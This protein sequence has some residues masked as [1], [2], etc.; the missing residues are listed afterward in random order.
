MSFDYTTHV[1]KKTIFQHCYKMPL[2]MTFDSLKS[3]LKTHAGKIC[4]THAA[5]VESL[6]FTLFSKESNWMRNNRQELIEGN[7]WLPNLQK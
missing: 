4:Q 6:S 7:K 2:K 3:G 5:Q 1:Y